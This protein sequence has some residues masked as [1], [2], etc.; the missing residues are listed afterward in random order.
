[1]YLSWGIQFWPHKNNL[2]QYK[3][4]LNHAETKN[5]AENMFQPNFLAWGNMLGL[6]K[7]KLDQ[8]N[9]LV[10]W[11]KPYEPMQNQTKQS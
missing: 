11:E 10:T 2:R 4:K 3:T 9:S 5:V 1:M 6:K 7:H 8:G